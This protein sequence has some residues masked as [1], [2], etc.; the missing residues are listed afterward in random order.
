MAA[1]STSSFSVSGPYSSDNLSG[2]RSNGSST[3]HGGHPPDGTR[4][5][6]DLLAEAERRSRDLQHLPIGHLINSA[7]DSA[8]YAETLADYRKRDQAYVEYMFA[9]E[10]IVNIIP[11][12]RDFV[13]LSS[14]KHSTLYAVFRETLHHIKEN[15][16]R[17]DKIKSIIIN[18][19]RRLG[20]MAR[21][22]SSTP[23]P[24]SRPMSQQVS[25]PAPRMNDEL[26][27]DSTTNGSTNGAKPL[28]P[29]RPHS[30]EV[31]GSLDSLSAA[32]SL[33]SRPPPRPK[34]Q[35]LHGNA[36][37]Q[38]SNHLNGS[39]DELS[40]RFARLR[41]AGNQSPSTSHYQQVQNGA[42]RMPSPTQYISNGTMGPPPRPSGPR[43]M[44]N[45]PPK[46][47]LDTQLAVQMP[48]PPSPTYSPARNMQTPQG[49]NPPR[50]TARSAVGSR[51]NSIATSSASTR[52]PGDNDGSSYFPSAL[53]RES[54]RPQDPIQDSSSRRNGS[55]GLP[56][57]GCEIE[58]NMLFDYMKMFR[59]L[60]IDVRSR[61]EFDQG[62]IDSATIVCIEPLTL[63]SGM[64]DEDLESTMIL[65]PD[66]ELTHFSRRD[67]FDLVVCYDYRTQTSAFLTKPDRNREEE[68]LRRLFDA[69]SELNVSKTLNRSPLLLTGGIEAWTNLLGDA[70]LRT[71]DTAATK[72]AK[73][74]Q[75]RRRPVPA[76]SAAATL[77]MEKRRRR[78]YNPLDPEEERRWLESARKE[79]VYIDSLP[80]DGESANSFDEE[81]EEDPAFYRTQA[82]FFRR[83]PAVSLEQESMTSPPPPSY[84]SEPYNSYKAGTPSQP[85]TQQ[86]S[87]LPRYSGSPSHDEM[88]SRPLPAAARVSYSGAHDRGPYNAPVRSQQELRPYVPIKDMPQNVRLPKTGL[89]NFGVTCYMNATI[90]CLNATIPLTMQIRNDSFRQ[91]VQR[92]NWKGSKGLVTE[93]YSNLIKS[94]WIGDVNACRPSTFRNLC[95]RMDGNW[96]ADVQQ[97]AKEFL[98]FVMECLHEDL[99]VNWR[100]PPPHVLSA[101]EEQFREKL[102]K[103]FAAQ[104]E[105]ARHTKREKSLISDLFAGQHCSQL[106]CL[107]CGHTSTTYEMFMSISVEI[108]R[109]GHSNI[110]ECLR[111]YCR[112]EKLAGGEKWMCPECKK[113][114][115]AT[116]RITITRA[117]RYLIVHFKRFAAGFQQSAKKVHTPID[118]P[119]CHLDLAEFM[120]PPPTDAERQRA[121]Q[122]TNDTKY[123]TRRLED[124]SLPPFTYDAYAVMR[125]LG[126]TLSSGHYVSLVRD[127]GRGKWR[128][129]NDDKVHDFTPGNDKSL[130]DGRAYIVFFER[131]GTHG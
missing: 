49:V 106:K 12:S 57:E 69:L 97:D 130:Q 115:E 18:D 103:P 102:A 124:S 11:R 105:W 41:G 119:L 60:L 6:D 68:A 117:P 61:Q 129:F 92:D 3:S 21:R 84:A 86:S 100:N 13:V 81:A 44:P 111:S 48:K 64:S 28:V 42:V 127:G 34:P 65:S 107:K 37:A 83:F 118:F 91:F 104:V 85:S 71:S 70:A 128:E 56:S 67:A 17:F 14:Q 15:N 32:N 2:S 120:A 59:V 35:S 29:P 53:S 10:L 98:E 99:N 113:E 27:L 43:E 109:S 62:H 31:F 94:L 77:A 66:N 54:S 87:H 110:Y 7:K 23:K 16:D 4:H 38:G 63:R 112:E 25:R 22:K 89:V 79:S 76:P 72:A 26:F 50:S 93:H 9:Y 96:G 20:I 39:T 75:P 5:I 114:R 101:E 24:P 47:P 116:K 95:A 52:A 51:S 121:M 45:I 30:V 78:E 126:A 80:M 108:P 90:Q 58:P 74:L 46:L 88:P 82:D 8:R 123:L 73:S 33:R 36:L 40:Q 131:T 19:N 122:A 55:F 125:H 1:A